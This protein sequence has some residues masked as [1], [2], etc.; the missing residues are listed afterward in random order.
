VSDEN[1]LLPLVYHNEAGDLPPI[2]TGLGVSGSDMTM[3]GGLVFD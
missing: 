2:L 1:P 3:G